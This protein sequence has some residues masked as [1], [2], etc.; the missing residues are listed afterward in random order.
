MGRLIKYFSQVEISSIIPAEPNPVALW[1]LWIF[2]LS[3]LGVLVLLAIT[4]IYIQRSDVDEQ[5][6]KIDS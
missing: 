2:T 6:V 1:R 4:V 3:F 5:N